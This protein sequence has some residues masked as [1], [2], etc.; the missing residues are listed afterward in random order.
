M[1]IPLLLMK[2]D[3]KLK[4]RPDHPP[5]DGTKNGATEG[6][7]V[8]H[9]V[10]DGR[11]T[12]KFVW[13]DVEAHAEAFGSRITHG[14][15]DARDE[16]FQILRFSIKGFGGYLS[17]TESF[18]GDQGGKNKELLGTSDPLQSLLL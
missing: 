18:I 10:A 1:A 14:H 6:D 2:P 15:V 11:Q 3:R 7:D 4:N 5:V 8:G 12:V 16:F 9:V 13:S 17:P